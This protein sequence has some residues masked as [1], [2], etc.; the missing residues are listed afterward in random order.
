MSGRHLEYH[1]EGRSDIPRDAL[2]A[3]A[4][5]L[6]DRGRA[7][8]FHRAADNAGAVVGPLLGLGLYELCAEIA[9]AECSGGEPNQ[10]TRDEREHGKTRD[11]DPVGDRIGT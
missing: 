7:F 3:A 6:E 2:I 9:P 4:V 5:R 8:G 10:G 1:G 11:V